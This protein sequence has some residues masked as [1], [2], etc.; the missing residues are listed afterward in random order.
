M[1]I[2]ILRRL[3]AAVGIM[4]ASSLLV[5]VLVINSGDPLWDLRESNA[6]NRELLI[7]Q[8]IE[9]MELDRPWYERYFGWLTGAAKCLIG[10][11]D[12]GVNRTGQEVMVV[13]GQAASSTLRLVFLATVIALIL[14]VAIGVL[15]A[16]R[17]SRASTTP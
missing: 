12:L 4:L 17:Q 11:C 13:L 7:Q 9:L 14:G 3:A 2:F 6:D 10:Q 8:R 1:L 15:T 5:Y 16:V